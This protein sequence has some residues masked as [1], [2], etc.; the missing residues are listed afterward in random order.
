MLLDEPAR[1]A[2]KG[3]IASYPDFP[4]PGIDFKDIAPVLADG[5][6]FGAVIRAMCAGLA[7]EGVDF[8]AILAIESRGFIFGAAIASHLDRGLILVRKPGKLPGPVA[9]FDYTCEY[10]TGVLEVHRDAIHPGGRYLVLDDLLA[11]GGTARAV[12]DHL[13]RLGGVVAGYC[14][15][16][17]L[18]FLEGRDRLADAP[19]MSLLTY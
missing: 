2:L 19:V 14:F 10:A 13:T 5:E 15:F 6:Q 7:S 1:V 11:T 18:T 12:A 3:S 8:D 4:T 9:T 16:V 17:E